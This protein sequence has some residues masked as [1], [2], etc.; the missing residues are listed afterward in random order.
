MAVR[1]EIDEQRIAD[2][3]RRHHIRR[4]ALLGSVL[5]DDFTAASDVDVVVRFDPERVPGFAFAR[6]Q[7]E[8]G[9]ILGRRVDPS[10]SGFLSPSIRERVEREA[11]SLYDADRR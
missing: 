3:Y 4:L 6:I 5:R 8:L 1:L 10:T 7:E 11:H 9:E 2:F